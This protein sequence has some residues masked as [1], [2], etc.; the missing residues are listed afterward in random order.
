MAL[1]AQVNLL[2]GIIRPVSN[3]SMSEC[4]SYPPKSEA[5]IIQRLITSLKIVFSL[6]W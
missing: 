2:A 4:Q 6:V 5:Q 1:T 3:L